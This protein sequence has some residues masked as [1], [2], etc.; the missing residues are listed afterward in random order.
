MLCIPGLTAFV[1]VQMEVHLQA[2]AQAPN[3]KYRRAYYHG[4]QNGNPRLKIESE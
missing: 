3:P 4:R 1:I 2:L